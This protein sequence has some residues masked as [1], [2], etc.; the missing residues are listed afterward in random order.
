MWTLHVPCLWV[1]QGQHCPRV[2]ASSYPPYSQITQRHNSI[3]L[4]LEIPVKDYSQGH[5][6]CLR[7][8]LRVANCLLDYL[9][10]AVCLFNPR[11]DA[12]LY[13]ISYF[14][15]KCSSPIPVWAYPSKCWVMFRN[16][17]CS[18]KFCGT[19]DEMEGGVK[20]RQSCLFFLRVAGADYLRELDKRSP[21]NARK[22]EPS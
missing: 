11:A 19:A 1:V 4:W 17:K 15:L 7:L 2:A 5:A 21:W 8:V 22:W 6:I 3:F 16:K 14:H 10:K 20:V 13:A 12:R 18:L 9:C